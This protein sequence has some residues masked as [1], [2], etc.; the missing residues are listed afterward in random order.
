MSVPIWTSVKLRFEYQKIAKNL[1]FFQ[2]NCQWQFFGKKWKLLIILF[3]KISSFWQFFDSQ[4]AIFRRGRWETWQC[5]WSVST[6][7]HSS[8]TCDRQQNVLLSSHEYGDCPVRCDLHLACVYHYTWTFHKYLSL[9]LFI[10]RFF[11]DFLCF[12]YFQNCRH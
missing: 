8:R 11:L 7:W 3:E 6:T 5:E 4:M 1:I 10:S 12:L 9:W 2:K